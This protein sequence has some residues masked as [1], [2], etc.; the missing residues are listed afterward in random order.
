MLRTSGAPYSPMWL[1]T[2]LLAF[3][4]LTQACKPSFNED[5]AC[6]T[7]QDCYSNEI[8]G[9][10]GTCVN[11]SSISEA[12]IS[13]FSADKTT[14]L[15]G[16][17][18][19]LSWSTTDATGATI[20]S[21]SGQPY[22]VPASDISR[23]S[24]TVTPT[25]TTTYTLTAT[26]QG[27]PATRELTVTIELPPAPSISS[28]TVDPLM[29]EPGGMVTLAWQMAGAASAKITGGPDPYI[30][31]DNELTQ[32]AVRVPVNDPTTFTLSAL[33]DAGEVMATVSVGVNGL[34]PTVSTFS[35]TP[36]VSI[37][38]EPVV[39]SWQTAGASSI[40]IADTSA[41][42]LDLTGQSPTA[43]QITVNPTRSTSY[44]LTA[45]NPFGS[46]PKSVEVTVLPKI[47]VTSFAATPDSV[48]AGLATTLSWEISG[49]PTSVEIQSD[50]GA[51]IPLGAASP[52]SGSVQ[53]TPAVTTLYT[54]T[55]KDDAQEV[56]ATATVTVLP[57]APTITSFTSNVPQIGAG[58]MITLSWV[59][60]DATTITLADAAGAMVDVTG[61]N[62][63]ADSVQL[64]PAAS[65]TYTLTAANAGG[66]A[67]ASV[68][69]TVGAPVTINA[70]TV[71]PT[72]VAAGD[73]VTLSWDISDAISLS[74]T[75]S[76]GAVVT[77]TGKSLTQD[78]V[79]VQPG[80][81]AITY[82]LTA[83]GFAGPVTAT[84]TVSVNAGV[85]ISDLSAT[86]NPVLAGQ[87][88]TLSWTTIS[89][90]S[91][92]L[93]AT[94]TG[95]TTPIDVTGKNAA[96]DTLSVSPAEDTT[97]TLTATDAMGASVTSTLD[98]TVYVAADVLTFTAS[99]NT[100]IAGQPITLTWTAVGATAI[101]ITDQ[102]GQMVALPMGANLAGDSVVV[103]P[104]STTSYTLVANGAQGTSDSAS[105]SVTVTPAPLLITELLVDATGADDGLEWVEL[106]N[107]GDTFVDLANYSL[108][109]GGA[110][111][112][113]TTV[114][115]A[116]LLPPK[117][118]AVI[119]GPTSSAANGSPTFFQSVTFT[120]NL[121]NG[122]A[123][124]ADGVALFALPAVN[125]DAT[126]VPMD[127]ILYDPA[128]GN[129]SGLLGEDGMPKTAISPL[130]PV[131]GSIERVSPTSDLFRAAATPTPGSC[132]TIAQL[133]GTKRAP[134]ESGGT[135]RFEGFG[136]DPALMTVHLGT[137]TLACSATMPGVYDC[138]VSAPGL[139]VTGAQD[140][141]ITQG[142]SYTADASGAP[143]VTPLGAPLTTTLPAAFFWE[144]H[145]EDT[146]ADFFCGQL[147]PANPTATPN[148][149]ISVS[150]EIYIAGVTNMGSG[151]LPAGYSVEGASFPRGELPYL[152]FGQAWSPAM[153]TATFSG[154][155]GSNVIYEST[156]TSAVAQ[157]AEVAVRVSPDG[158]SY[159]YCD[160]STSN[161][162]DDGWNL[163]GGAAIEW[164]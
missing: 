64:S 17:S 48:T 119:G 18:V 85:A 99:S 98:V 80:T 20:T 146:S 47:T 10:N 120:P 142:S 54:I 158:V 77:T 27:E 113:T 74:I 101:S 19:T 82:T 162:S 24:T 79:T 68:M 33:N 72:S 3:M 44:T 52:T 111:Y 57:L 34:P 4:T 108:G 25:E 115:L 139:M 124:G 22:T 100:A 109:A 104:Q 56:S 53:V 71:T 138:P 37:E 62:P 63:L 81:G 88:I 58:G 8:C 110:D 7:D 45:T 59:T 97:Y 11:A 91:I 70:F 126:T 42:M 14:I 103:R 96:S 43:G 136:F 39:L 137:Q 30:I 12:A 94:T 163:N 36:A 132:A 106:Y 118:C 84:A 92:A 151:T 144:G 16:E 95:G 152:R 133:Q 76:D 6:S 65:T 125:L 129:S 150:S 40:T 131:G 35:A 31:P 102:R 32:G 154:P 66:M 86:P 148:A 155:F 127:A 116:G 164:Q 140:L 28:F 51:L 60:V 105:A 1:A 78:S 130:P 160:L 156:F 5:N 26:G 49:T 135:L 55:A 73:P 83:D 159:Y 41:N 112:L 87:P 9:P 67:S 46:K 147:T 29:V 15:A 69:I 21:P 107:P 121:Q 89:A 122:G 90:A 23:G 157:Q 93:T 134:N 75:S 128:G 117:G 13:S 145:L 141:V 143:V 161:G 38:G 123:G 61:K 153:Q 2:A 149:P 50:Q 114:Q